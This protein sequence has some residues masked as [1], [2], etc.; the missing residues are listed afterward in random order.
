MMGKII[1]YILLIH[2]FLVS[3]PFREGERREE[4]WIGF[5]NNMKGKVN[6]RTNNPTILSFSFFSRREKEEKEDV[7][8]RTDI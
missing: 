5:A 6:S 7:S 1:I 3:L 2:Y 4:W 8:N